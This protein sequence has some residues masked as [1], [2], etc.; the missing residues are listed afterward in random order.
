MPLSLALGRLRQE[1][2]KLR[3][4]LGYIAIDSLSLGYIVLEQTKRS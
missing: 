2:H 3:A 1:D 4:G